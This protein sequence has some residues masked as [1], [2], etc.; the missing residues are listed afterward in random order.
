VLFPSDCSRLARRAFSLLR[1]R[2]SLSRAERLARLDDA[3][4]VGDARLL[5]RIT[6]CQGGEKIMCL[7]AIIAVAASSDNLHLLP[8]FHWYPD[9]IESQDVSGP[10]K[11]GNTWH[12][13]VDCIP[14]GDPTEVIGPRAG[15]G[16]LEWCHFTSTDLVHWSEHPVAI[17]NDRDFDGAI[18]DTGAVFQHPNG[19]VL[20]IYATAN[21][22]SL[23]HTFDGDICIAVAEDAHGG[24]DG[25]GGLLRWRKLCDAPNGRI[26]NPAC[27]WCRQ[28]CPDSCKENENSTAPSPFPGIQPKFNHRDPTAPWLDACSPSGSEQCWYVLVASGGKLA[29][30]GGAQRSVVTL[31]STDYAISTS[32]RYVD[33]FWDGPG[34]GYSCPDF[35]RIPGTDL[36]R[37]R[38]LAL[39][40]HRTA[41]GPGR[42]SYAAASPHRLGP[43]SDPS[44]RS[45]TSPPFRPS[46]C[47]RHSGP[48]VLCGDLLAER[49]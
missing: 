33:L 1:A 7:L 43:G 15:L 8:R 14:E 28:T 18:I 29:S 3:R 13:F 27:H 34:G 40:A 5:A 20:A 17:R 9:T 46:G 42:P 11:I 39:A 26:V 2:L 10:I 44:C 24:L 30:R 31:W 41:T 45:L 37:C 25:G 16:P 19:T 47:L 48:E 12:V 38:P 49:Q 6:R 22:T 35:F 23:A 4:R 36:V 21:T 32:W